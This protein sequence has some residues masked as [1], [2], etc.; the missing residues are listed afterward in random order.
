MREIAHVHPIP[1]EPQRRWFTSAE[2]DL[3]VWCDPAGTPLG[4]E[5]CYAQH[6][7]EHALTWHRTTGFHQ[8]AVE[9]GAE[10]PGHA[11]ASPWLRANGVCDV[12]RVYTL[13][14]AASGTMPQ[15]IAVFVQHVLAT[16]PHCHASATPP[17]R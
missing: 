2:L 6:D 15:E 11:K 7:T 13:F 4:F 10:R 3:L 8:T 5:L 1:S 16:Y 9:E 17:P 14:C 12:R